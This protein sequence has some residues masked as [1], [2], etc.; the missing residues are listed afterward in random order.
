MFAHWGHVDSIR[1][2]I[3]C[4]QK[5]EKIVKKYQTAAH[6][7]CFQAFGTGFWAARTFASINQRS[8]HEPPLAFRPATSLLSRP[9]EGSVGE[10]IRE[11][12]KKARLMVK[13]WITAWLNHAF[14]QAPSQGSFGPLRGLAPKREPGGTGW[15]LR[16]NP[17]FDI[18]PPPNLHGRLQTWGQLAKPFGI[19]GS[20]RRVALG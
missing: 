1:I 7:R 6:S 9:D 11:R 5:N 2:L 4:N 14:S 16:H 8:L 18:A 12:T 19:A 10:E 20:H 17:L 15:R 3:L 13:P